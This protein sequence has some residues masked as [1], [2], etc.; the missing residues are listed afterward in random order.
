MSRFLRTPWRS[1]SAAR[2]V[3]SA[4]LA[5]GVA[6]VR[7]L[8]AFDSETA[9]HSAA[10]ALYSRDVA[11]HLGADADS[12]AA[13]QLGALVHDVG[14]LALPAELLLKAEPLDEDEWALV[15]EH[16]EAGARIVAGLPSSHTLLAI[17]RHHHERVDGRGYPQGLRGSEIPAAARIVGACDAYAAMTQHRPYRDSVDARRCDRRAAAQRRRPVRRGGRGGARLGARPGRRG[18]PPRA[19]A[20]LYDRAPARR[21]RRAGRGAA[22]RRAS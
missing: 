14:K 6:L 4:S 5:T 2:A 8:A 9:E 21:A 7:A 12:A 17:V 20:T 22:A 11:L 3:D 19:R 10:V 13:I 18:L 1:R 15:R 16:P